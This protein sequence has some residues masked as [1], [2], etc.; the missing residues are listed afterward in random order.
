MS[1]VKWTEE[2]DKTIIE[3]VQVDDRGFVI[4]ALEVSEKIGRSKKGTQTRI[5]ELRAQGKLA[6]P[7]YDDI[8]FPVRKSYSKQ[9][10]KFIKNAY[11]SG[12]TYQEIADALGRSFRA[13]QLRISRLRKKEEFSY[14]REPWSKSEKEE[15]LENVRFDRFG[16]VANVDELARII[17][18]PKRE[19]GRKISVMR[20]SGDIG[21]LPDRT[22]CSLNARKALR[23]ANDYHYS[24][25]ILYK[26][27][28]KEPT[29]VTASEGKNI[30]N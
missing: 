19:V 7:Y 8:L 18:R 5:K 9:E 6:R 27:A 3:M 29:P 12:A 28:K 26:G 21:V 25:A 16:Y 23:E 4:N 13:I 11:L 10:D 1:H 24:L 15:L 14:H 20:K 22:T 30:T 2:E 17:G